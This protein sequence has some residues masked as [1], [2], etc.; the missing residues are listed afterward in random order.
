MHSIHH[1]TT[2]ASRQK[3]DAVFVGGPQNNQVEFILEVTTLHNCFGLAGVEH[4][5]HQNQSTVNLI[6]RDLIDEREVV[7][8][9]EERFLD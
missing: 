4:L 9:D 8:V 6:A 7:L 2:S 3:T 5:L 1:H